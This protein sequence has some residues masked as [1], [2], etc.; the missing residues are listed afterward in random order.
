M[1]IIIMFRIISV[2]LYEGLK[3]VFL[4]VCVVV[5]IFVL[6]GRFDLLFFNFVIVVLGFNVS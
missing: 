4:V 3:Y 2:L 6:V 5:D 1:V